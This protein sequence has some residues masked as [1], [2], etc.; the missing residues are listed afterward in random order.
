[1]IFFVWT[2]SKYKVKSR[3]NTYAWI[4]DT[5]ISRTTSKIKQVITPILILTLIIETLDLRRQSNR[6]PAVMLAIK[7]T[8]RVN[9]R[10]RFLTSSIK[11]INLMSAPGVPFGTKWANA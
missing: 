10:M 1:M 3:V 8:L 5:A 4:K 2:S 7:R 6:C 9:G 11:T